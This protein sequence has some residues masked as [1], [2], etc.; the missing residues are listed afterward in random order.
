MPFVLGFAAGGG[1]TLRHF[2]FN[3]QDG[4]AAH[5]RPQSLHSKDCG[6]CVSMKSAP[7]LEGGFFDRLSDAVRN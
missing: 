5:L 1:S 3:A 2:Y 6:V 7:T 4:E